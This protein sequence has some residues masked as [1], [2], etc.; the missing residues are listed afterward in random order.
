MNK[1]SIHSTRLKASLV[2]TLMLCAFLSEIKTFILESEEM[3]QGRRMSLF[4][5][6]NNYENERKSTNCC[7]AMISMYWQH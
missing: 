6:K 5:N 3:N 2:I 7:P 1:Q 4:L